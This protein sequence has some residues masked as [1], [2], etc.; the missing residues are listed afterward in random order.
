MLSLSSS[1]YRV[2][3][4]ADESIT[5]GIVSP[6]PYWGPLFQIRNSYLPLGLTVAGLIADYFLLYSYL[7]AAFLNS[8]GLSCT[9]Q[10]A[11]EG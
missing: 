3:G 7:S 1:A 9:A 5:P 11:G 8:L 10:R 6:T 4:I 2:Q